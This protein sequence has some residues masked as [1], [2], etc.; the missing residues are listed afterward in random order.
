MI[1]RQLLQEGAEALQRAG[2]DTPVLDAEL[3]LAHAL[4]VSRSE[5]WMQMHQDADE[6]VRAHFLQLV[7]RRQKREPMAYIL[8]EKEF[9]SLPFFVTPS[10]LIPRPE[11][12]HL[13]EAFLK[14]FPER[15]Q[16]LNICDLGTGSGCLAVT[17]ATLYPRA[18]VTAC[19]IDPRALAIAKRN[20][21][22]HRVADRIA[23]R[24]GD[25][26]AALAADPSPFDALITNP[27]YLTLAEYQSA[28]PEL[29]YEPRHALTDNS[30]DLRLMRRIL[31]EAPS[32]VRKGGCVVM[33]CGQRGLP[34]SPIG[35]RLVEKI[36]DLAG[37]L[38][39]GIFAIEG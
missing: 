14:Q 11:S 27:P 10:V 20:A 23:F 4:G 33:E 8:G 39:G 37:H 28:P 12:E 26:F 6:Q 7:E 1:Y 24:Q 21:E 19:D 35:L 32:F 16:P 3:L 18:S 36:T 9:W 25:L 2:C 15:E 34:P 17:L 31:A 38:R 29:A 30:C 5:L 22:R 13:I